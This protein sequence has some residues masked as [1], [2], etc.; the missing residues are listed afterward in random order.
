ML[1]IVD[2]AKTGFTKK[3]ALEHKQNLT[4]ER[5]FFIDNMNNLLE[6]SLS[7]YTGSD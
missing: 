6:R 7:L 3:E 2:L 5:K 1:A 4:T